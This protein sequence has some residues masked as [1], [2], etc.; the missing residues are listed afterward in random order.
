MNVMTFINSNP[1][2]NMIYILCDLC[3]LC[4]QK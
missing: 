1:Q 2:H 3:E 4:G